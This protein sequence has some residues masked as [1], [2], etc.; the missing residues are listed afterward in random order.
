MS[1]VVNAD[2]FQFGSSRV[3]QLATAEVTLTATQVKALFTTPIA[4][5][6]ALGSGMVAIVHRI[7]IASTFVSVAYTG[8]NALEFRYTNASGAKVTPDIAAATLNFSSGTK[9]ATVAGVATE[10]AMVA[11]AA[12]VVCVPTG[13]PAAGDSPITFFV[14]YMAVA[15]P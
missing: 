7:T 5:V 14:E 4:L 2:Y 11:N 6:A 3:A 1:R 9:L 15:L 12:I 10:L 13:N 8:S